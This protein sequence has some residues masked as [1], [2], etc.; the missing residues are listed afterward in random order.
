MKKI[1]KKY[2][3]QFLV[4][5]GILVAGVGFCLFLLSQNPAS[6]SGEND[7]KTTP[8]ISEKKETATHTPA[9]SANFNPGIPAF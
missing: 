6:T 8:K 9:N 2:R 4:F 7:P 5:A 1:W 3:T